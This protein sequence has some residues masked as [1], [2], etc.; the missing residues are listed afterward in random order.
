MVHKHCYEGVFRRYLIYLLLSGITLEMSGGGPGE[1]IVDV[2]TSISCLF[3]F[4][5]CLRT[6]C[7][8]FVVESIENLRR[9]NTERLGLFPTILR[10]RWF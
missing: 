5:I 7:T 4:K 6:D 8:G 2:L 3:Y 9:R 1:Y 10:R